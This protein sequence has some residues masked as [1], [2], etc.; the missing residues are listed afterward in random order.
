MVGPAA[1]FATHDGARIMR[2]RPYAPR[3]TMGNIRKYVP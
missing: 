1:L 3:D 2:H